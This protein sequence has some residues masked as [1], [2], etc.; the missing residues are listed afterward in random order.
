MGRVRAGIFLVVLGASLLGI[1]ILGRW[2]ALGRY[3][4]FPARSWERFDPALAQST[5]DLGS[6]FRAARA[7]APRPLGKMGPGEKMEVLY[8][9]VADRFT[10]G[11]RARYSPFANWILWTL[12]AAIPRYRDIQ[13]PD[14]LLRGGHSALCGEVSYVLMRLAGMAGIPTRHVL[15]EGHIVMEARY[16]GKWHAYDPDFEVVARDESGAVES[17]ETLERQPDLVRRLYAGRGDEAFLETIIA[18]YASAENNAYFLYPAQS[19]FGPP[20]QRPGRVEETAGYL[21][22]LLPVV[23]AAAGFALIAAGLRKEGGPSQR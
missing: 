18:I 15:L 4:S 6:L 9:T 1:S 8:G 16:D 21:V 19:L 11:D 12:G 10:H 7:R 2:T 20:G 23:P 13:D 5:P 22:F 17:V 3:E 14:I